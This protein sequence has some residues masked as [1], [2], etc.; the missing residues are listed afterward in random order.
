[1]RSQE[2][3]QANRNFL[4]NSPTGILQMTPQ[5]GGVVRAAREKKTNPGKYLAHSRFVKFFIMRPWP[6]HLETTISAEKM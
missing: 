2:F 3:M 1:V 6:C 5:R 4:E